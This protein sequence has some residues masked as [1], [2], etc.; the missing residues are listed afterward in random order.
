[1]C[2]ALVGLGLYRC[3]LGCL[4]YSSLLFPLL[5]FC[6]S[7]NP[8]LKVFFLGDMGPAQISA[9]CQVVGHYQGRVALVRVCSCSSEGCSGPLHCSGLLKVH[10]HRAAALIHLCSCFSPGAPVSPSPGRRRQAC[11]RQRC[12]SKRKHAQPQWALWH[13]PLAPRWL[14]IWRDKVRKVSEACQWHSVF[15]ALCQ[16]KHS[17]NF[18]PPS[19]YKYAELTACGEPSSSQAAGGSELSPLGTWTQ[20][21]RAFI[22]LPDVSPL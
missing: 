13:Q 4:S 16:Q 5:T 9:L 18:L 19:P 1:M 2:F 17:S 7:V 14:S 21:H 8:I 10:G 15:R 6:L 20:G 11:P 22:C 12:R 3:L